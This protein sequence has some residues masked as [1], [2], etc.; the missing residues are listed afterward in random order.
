MGG[1]VLFFKDGL[2]GG[3]SFG[4]SLALLSGICF[5]LNSVILRLQKEGDT[6]D[7]LLLAHFLTVAAGIPFYIMHPPSFTAGNTAAILFLGIFQLCLA[8]LV[9][10]YGIKRVPAAQAMLTA[11]IEP[12]LNPIWVLLVIG[13][14]PAIVALFGGAIIIAAV[15]ISTVRFKK[16]TAETE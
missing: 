13:E 9:F 12:I 8:S 15:L 4:N 10:A 7:A 14:K 16:L 2:E 11:A 3:S 6:A 1:L 5:A